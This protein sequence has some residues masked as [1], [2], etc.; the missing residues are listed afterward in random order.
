MKLY[1][2][3][4]ICQN[5]KKIQKSQVGSLNGP[6]LSPATQVTMLF[7]EI[8]DKSRLPGLYVYEERPEVDRYK[9]GGQ[10]VN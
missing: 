1:T 2:R 6:I 7:A 4:T 3:N 5:S 8:I 9:R 10:G